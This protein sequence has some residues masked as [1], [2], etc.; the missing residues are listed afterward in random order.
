MASTKQLSWLVVLEKM[1]GF[2]IMIVGVIVFY[3]T[4][5]NIKAAGLASYFFIGIGIALMI[6][7]LILLITRTT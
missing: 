3:N 4:Y 7:G 2:V 6:L 1:I 5:S